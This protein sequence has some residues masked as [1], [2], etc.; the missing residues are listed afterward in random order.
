MIAFGD[1]AFYLFGE[2]LGDESDRDRELTL[3]LY[4]LQHRV[5]KGNRRLSDRVRMATRHFSEFCV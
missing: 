4:L 1:L 2:L 5:L 3:E